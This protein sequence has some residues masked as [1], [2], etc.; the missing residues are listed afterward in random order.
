LLHV[1][2]G[3]GIPVLQAAA[4][5]IQETGLTPR[6]GDEFD[7]GV[8]HFHVPRRR[9]PGEYV[10]AALWRQEFDRLVLASNKDL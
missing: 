2:S 7:P 4:I 9:I 3:L 1:G 10:L 6:A 5:V 8:C